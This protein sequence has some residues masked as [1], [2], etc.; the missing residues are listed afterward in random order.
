MSHNVESIG[1]A[2][3][4]ARFDAR[5]L[6]ALIAE[7]AGDVVFEPHPLGFLRCRMGVCDYGIVYLH[8]WPGHDRYLQSQ[9]LTIHQ[10]SV[11][12]VSYVIAGTIRDIT[13]DWVENAM[14]S[15]RLLQQ[16]RI[17]TGPRLAST[18]HVGDLVERQSRVIQAG[19]CYSIRQDRFHETIVDWKSN[20]ATVAMFVG[21][22]NRTPFAAAPLLESN[23]RT[24]CPRA[25][26]DGEA[27]AILS[28]VRS[29]LLSR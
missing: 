13:Y 3:F 18:V 7:I 5:V 23:D 24:Y 26:A 17:P 16:N 28:I 22:S 11:T 10:H 20:V 19:Q 6:D 29:A 9:S 4:E 14:G 8:C 1:R 12:V 15:K 27:A 2:L 21:T 25:L